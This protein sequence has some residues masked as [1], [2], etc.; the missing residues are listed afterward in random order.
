V[1]GTVDDVKVNRL[2]TVK[3]QTCMSGGFDHDIVL[4]STADAIYK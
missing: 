2:K 3:K 1:N 4:A